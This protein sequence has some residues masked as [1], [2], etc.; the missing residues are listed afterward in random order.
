MRWSSMQRQLALVPAPISVKSTPVTKRCLWVNCG[1]MMQGFKFG[2]RVTSESP[3]RGVAHKNVGSVQN[4]WLERTTKMD[5]RR[6]VL[7][8]SPLMNFLR[9]TKRM[10]PLMPSGV[11]GVMS[12]SPAVDLS[13]SRAAKLFRLFS[14]ASLAYEDW[15]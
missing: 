9:L 8:R 6:H 5:T 15:I 13:L 11:P 10:F 4:T 12:G 1:F 14:G 3:S 7:Q 2:F